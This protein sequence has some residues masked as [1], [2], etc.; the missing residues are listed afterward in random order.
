MKQYFQVEETV[1]GTFFCI[2]I[3]H[4]CSYDTSLVGQCV[5]AMKL[6]PRN[7]INYIMKAEKTRKTIYD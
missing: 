1:K 5:E 7:K 4:H 2:F 3:C 6:E